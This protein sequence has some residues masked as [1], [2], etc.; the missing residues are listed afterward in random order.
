MNPQQP[1]ASPQQQVAYFK[2]QADAAKR[3]MAVQKSALD[4]VKRAA[5]QGYGF[6][7]A[8]EQPAPRTG[9][10]T[11]HFIVGMLT[12][13]ALAQKVQFEANIAEIEE[14][15]GQLE[16]IIKQLDSP[17]LHLGKLGAS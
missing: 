14:N 2:S 8:V 16:Q 9:Q 6:L 15:L 13:M 10:E 11:Y 7:T 3:R 4:S 1:S 5:E 17:I 12:D